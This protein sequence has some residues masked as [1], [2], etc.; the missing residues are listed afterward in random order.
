[1]TLEDFGFVDEF[2]VM[3]NHKLEAEEGD[4]VGGT[5]IINIDLVPPEPVV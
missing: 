2:R 4:V 3:D 1:M 5:V